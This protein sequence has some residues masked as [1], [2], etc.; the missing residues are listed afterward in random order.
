MNERVTL[1]T[2]V[3]DI[4]DAVSRPLGKAVGLPGAAFNDPGFMALENERL[5]ARTWVA[6]ALTSDIPEPGDA[7]PIEVAG[8]PLVILR[9]RDGQVRSFHNICRHRAM[10]V[11]AERRSGLKSLRCPWHPWTNGLNGRLVATPNLV[12]IGK[13]EAEGFDKSDL[14]LQP[15]RVDT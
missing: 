10:T 2:V 3:R 14:G 9:N 8:L 4:K 13:P 12:G 7:V 5:F 1:D 11:V 15:V 6:A